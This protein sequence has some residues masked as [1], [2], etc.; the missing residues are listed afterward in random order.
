MS[1]KEIE[2]FN[3]LF[4]EFLE[5]IISKFPYAKLKSYYRGF[6]IL[7]STSPATPSN[8]FMAGC[9]D[10]KVQIRQ[11]DDQFF[12]K[13]KS[14]NSKAKNFGN[15]TEDCGL[16]TYWNE[17]TPSTKKAIWDYIQSLFVLGEIIV[18]KH[19]D[20]FDKYNTMY[21]SDYKS[22]I[23]NLHTDNFSVEFLE[24]IK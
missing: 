2:N 4:E 1:S 21:A 16:D 18:N 17:L 23:N 15:F 19:K 8:L 10:Y 14:V 5:K 20:L 22:E 12:L 3:K 7:K 6:K 24:K 9:V 11:R 13:D